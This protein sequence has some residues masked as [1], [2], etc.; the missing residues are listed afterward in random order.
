MWCNG[1]MDNLI[2]SAEE[3]RLLNLFNDQETL[4][5]I[6]KLT[7]KQVKIPEVRLTK[8]GVVA[9]LELTGAMTLEKVQQLLPNL[10]TVLDVDDN[11]DTDVRPGGRATQAA[12]SIR[13]R[14]V[15]DAMDMRWRPGIE[16]FGVDTVTGEE[17]QVS[18]DHRLV[19]AGAPGAGKS[20]SLRPLMARSVIR[21][22]H[23]VILVDGKGDEANVWRGVVQTAVDPEEI[24]DCIECEYALMMKRKKLMRDEGITVW[25]TSLGPLRIFVVDEGR[26]VLNFIEKYDQQLERGETLVKNKLLDLDSLGRSRGMVVVWATQYPIVDGPDKGIDRGVKANVEDNICLR[27]SNSTHARVVLDDFGAIYKP[28][29]IKAY[30]P[31]KAKEGEFD[32]RGHGFVA[33][34][35]PNLVRAWTLTDDDV[36][37]L[38][39]Y[40]E[41][42]SSTPSPESAEQK[43]MGV[44]EGEMLIG[45]I[46]GKFGVSESDAFQMLKKLVLS[47]KV[48]CRFTEDGFRY[49]II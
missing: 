35:G 40:K 23:R 19:V 37:N 26:V 10:R 24:I 25:D 12:L 28:H 39:K 36:R 38:P 48:S 15:T 49:R 46:A 47:E 33:S 34:H 17:V 44:L 18:W 1:D 45:E 13:T 29:H 42:L 20:W 31:E 9:R 8:S 11:H 16:S 27:V 30:N 43:L 14:R 22:D 7:R 21:E 32:T 4:V 3:T 6:R 41:Q 5:A 2:P